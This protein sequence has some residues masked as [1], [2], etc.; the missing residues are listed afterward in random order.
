MSFYCKF[1]IKN[2]QEIYLEIQHQTGEKDD[3]FTTIFTKLVLKEMPCVI[4]G[5]EDEHSELRNNNLD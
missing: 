4:I 1:T 2:Y 3:F 5:K